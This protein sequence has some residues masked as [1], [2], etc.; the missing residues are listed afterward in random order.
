[1]KHLKVDQLQCAA[2]E[3]GHRK[4]VYTFGKT[5]YSK[6]R[7]PREK[8]GGAPHPPFSWTNSIMG[9]THPLLSVRPAI[10][11]SNRLDESVSFLLG[12]NVNATVT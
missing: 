6:S 4:K 8:V 5:K 11:L 3:L 1:M 7:G 12:E 9:M 10:V 2:T